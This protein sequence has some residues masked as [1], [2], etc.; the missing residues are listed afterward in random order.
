MR[1]LAAATLLLVALV[2]GALAPKIWPDDSVG[3]ALASGRPAASGPLAK[4]ASTSFAA[5]SWKGKDGGTGYVICGSTENW[6]RPTLAEQNA[7]LAFD[8]RYAGMRADDPK[9]DASAKFGTRVLLY[10]GSSV[11]AR[12][13]L[14][15]LTGMWTDPQIGGNAVGCTS[16]E[17]QVWLIGYEPIS[18]RGSPGVASLG[19]RE[20]S[21]YRMVVVTGQIGTDLV[22]FDSVGK[23]AVFDVT[24]WR[25]PTPT[26][27]P[28]VVPTSKAESSSSSTTFPTTD[29]P[30]ELALPAGCQILR[31]S[32]HVDDFGATW[33]VQC[34]SAEANLAVAVAA[35]RQGWSHMQG[36]PIGVGMQTYMKGTLS[37]QIAYRLD[38]PAFADPFQIVQYSRPFAQGAEVAPPNPNVYLRVPSGFDLPT[39][40]VWREAPV[41]F[42]D[43]GAYRMPFACPAIKPEEIQVTFTQ[44]MESQGWYVDN[45]GFG[46]LTYAKGDLRLTA[47]FVDGKAGPTDVPWVVESL[48]CFRP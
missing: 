46:F 43:E 1:E 44:A 14:V 24:P 28:K 21:G 37:M 22:I 47:T 29:R 42:T 45:G 36:P 15:A 9:S 26:P 5:V 17:P 33:S 6:S 3:A 4:V 2:I 16:T 8:P 35:L 40:C 20:A 31:Q 39:G 30:L 48:C 41:G 27:A 12:M 19:V 18:F 23:L 7:H 38:G 10:D 11:S 32:R 25:G 13:D 34:G